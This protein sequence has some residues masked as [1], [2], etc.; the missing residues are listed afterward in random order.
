MINNLN[1][2]VQ[3]QFVNVEKTMEKIGNGTDEKLIDRNKFAVQ[4]N[5]I[6]LQ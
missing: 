4:C 1:S 3:S 6:T 5:T 2:K